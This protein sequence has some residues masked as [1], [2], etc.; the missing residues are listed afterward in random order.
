[1]NDTANAVAP[2]IYTNSLSPVRSVFLAAIMNFL[3]VLT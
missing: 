2:V 1:M 3:G